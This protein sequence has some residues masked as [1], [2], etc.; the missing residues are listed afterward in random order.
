MR[1]VEHAMSDC[2]PKPQ[3]GAAAPKMRYNRH[4]REGA[5]FDSG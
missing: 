2:L 3:R 1:T 4:D 5:R